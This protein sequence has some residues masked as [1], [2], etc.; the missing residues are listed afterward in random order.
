MELIS[1]GLIHEMK[2]SQCLGLA[3]DSV[4]RLNEYP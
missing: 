4:V 3:A 1:Y 2:Q